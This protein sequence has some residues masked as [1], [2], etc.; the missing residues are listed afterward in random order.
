LLRQGISRCFS[1]DT[2]IASQRNFE[3]NT[4]AIAL[5][6]S[7]NRLGATRWCCDIPC[8][9]GHMLGAGFKKALD[10]ATTGKM[11]ALCSQHNHTHIIVFIQ[12]LKYQT[13]LVTL[14][15]RND[16]EWWTSQHDIGTL[17]LYVNLDTEA[18]QIGQ[19]FLCGVF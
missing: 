9:L 11:L 14:R 1:H 3:A 5:V 2:E 13:Q 19:L 15:H 12:R 10:V 4:K 18:I 17:L 8:E 7:N 6:H 16:V